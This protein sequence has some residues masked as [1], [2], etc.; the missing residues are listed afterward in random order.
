MGTY[1]RLTRQI[2]ARCLD[3]TGYHLVAAAKEVLVVGT[4]GTTVG[5]NQPRL[6]LA[7]GPSTTLS[8][9]GRGWWHIA[10]M[11]QFQV[12]DVNAQFHRW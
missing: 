11:Y 6:A 8:V 5:D 4:V 7:S 3:T 2:N 12:G 10:Q 9:V 1:Q